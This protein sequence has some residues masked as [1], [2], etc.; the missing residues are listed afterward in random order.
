MT[1]NNQRAFFE[2]VRAGLWEKEARLL[3]YGAVDYADIMRLAQE[4]AVVGLVAAGLEHV[5]DVKVPKEEVLQFVGQI[6]QLEQR[7]IMKNVY[8]WKF[9]GKNKEI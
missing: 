3:P 8:V 6:L 2:L 9:I 1:Y 5:T 4:P 7:N